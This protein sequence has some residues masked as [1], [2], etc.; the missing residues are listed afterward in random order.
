MVIPVATFRE[1]DAEE[2][3]PE[4]RHVAPDFPTRHHVNALHDRNEN[5]QSQG[6]WHEQ[7][8]V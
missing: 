6:Q 5:R 3:P 2:Q 4:F 8:M 1:I 7:E